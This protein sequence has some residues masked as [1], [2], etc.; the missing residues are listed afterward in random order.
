[1][2]AQAAYFIVT[3]AWANVHRS[4]F[5]RISG[6]KQDYWLARIVGVLVLVIGVT[7]AA[8]AARRKPAGEAVAL[9]ATSAAALGAMEAY[10]AA[11]RRISMVYMLDAAVEATLIAAMAFGWRRRPRTPVQ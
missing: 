1:M 8:H 6:R 5:E 9:A 7:L 10:Y 11:R 3:G 2:L 4:S